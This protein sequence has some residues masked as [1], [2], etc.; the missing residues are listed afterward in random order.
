MARGKSV[1][2]RWYRS[3]IAAAAAA[4]AI[5]QMLRYDHR[6]GFRAYNHR[7]IR[8]RGKRGRSHGGGSHRTGSDVT[9]PDGALRYS[10]ERD[11]TKKKQK[12][13]GE[14]AERRRLVRYRPDGVVRDGTARRDSV[15]DGTVRIRTVRIGM[16]PDGAIW[17]GAAQRDTEPNGTVW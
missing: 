1:R 9:G 15:L 5:K 7:C 6:F 10:T 17:H 12:I 4:V 16:E 8:A 2:D 11:W 14:V 13:T 3:E